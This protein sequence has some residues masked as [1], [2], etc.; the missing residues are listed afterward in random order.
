[1]YGLKLTTVICGGNCCDG[2]AN[3]VTLTTQIGYILLAT[4]LSNNDNNDNE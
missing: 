1:M 2:E 4:Y 3:E